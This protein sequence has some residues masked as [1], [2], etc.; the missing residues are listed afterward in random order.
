[1]ESMRNPNPYVNRS[2]CSHVTAA[3]FTSPI[4][5]PRITHKG[6]RLVRV[7]TTES[8]LVVP[9]AAPKFPT[10]EAALTTHAPSLLLLPLTRFR[11]GREADLVRRR[12]M[13]FG[14]ICLEKPK[15]VEEGEDERERE[16]RGER[17]EIFAPLFTARETDMADAMTEGDTWKGG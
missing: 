15:T 4:I 14:V 13:D 16:E 1:M 10:S 7:S 11:C 17:E 12:E 3:G 2:V 5:V 8:N 6:N 9:S